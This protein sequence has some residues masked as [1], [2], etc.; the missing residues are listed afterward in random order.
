MSERF[1]HDASL[2][3]ESREICQM[4]GGFPPSRYRM[5]V[6]DQLGSQD[7][8]D[9]FEVALLVSGDKLLQ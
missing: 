2:K 9:T 4:D 5:K 1:R 7:H 8:F 3:R 6:K